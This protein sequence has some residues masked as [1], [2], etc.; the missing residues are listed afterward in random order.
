MLLF[1]LD[2]IRLT[3]TLLRFCYA[4]CYGARLGVTKTHPPFRGGVTVTLAKCYGK[5]VHLK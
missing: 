4:H 1:L 5:L 3:V 2:K